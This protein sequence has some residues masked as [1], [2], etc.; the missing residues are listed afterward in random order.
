MRPAD[1]KFWLANVTDRYVRGQMDRRTFLRAASRLGLGAAALGVGSSLARR[2]GIG[3][4]SPAYAQQQ[5]EW[6]E[7][8]TNWL[9]EAAKPF[10]G[11]TI[12]LATEST[13]PSNAINSAL[14]G[15]FVETTGINV[16]IETLPLEQVL[17]KLTLD[18]ASGL[19]TYDLYYLD[20]SWMA[21]F[22]GD[23]IDPREKYESDANL[24]MPNYN[25]DD[26]LPAL[27]DGIS[28]YDGIMVGVPY[29]I[30]IFIQMYRK[31][32][33]D[34]LGLTPATTMEQ[35]LSNA[36]AIQEAK[37][38]DI[39]GTT[40]QMKSGHYSLECDWTAWLWGHGGSVF[41]PDGKFTGNDAA[42]LEAMNYWI[43]LKKTMPEAVTSWTWDG[44]GQSVAQGIAGQILSWGE[45]FPS[46]DD[47]NS[48]QVS[49]LMEA[50][51]PPAATSLRTVD[52]TGYG[53]IPGV[54]HQGGSSLAVSKYSKS[55]G[56]GLALCAMGDLA[57]DPGLDHRPRRWHRPDPLLGLRRP[58]G[59]GERQGRDR[60][61]HAPPRRGARD[62]REPYGLRARPAGL[63]RDLER[64][65]PG[66]A[67][68]VLGRRVR[69]PTGGPRSDQGN[70][71]R[72]RREGLIARH[73]GPP[74]S[75]GAALSPNLRRG[76]DPCPTSRL[77]RSPA[78]R[79]GSAPPPRAP[80]PARGT[81]SC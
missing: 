49:G 38:P 72:H 10:A 33:Y 22:S 47:P 15:Y 20:Q 9:R 36:Q 63:G 64:H 65:D 80:L 44:Q 52:Q 57:R 78:P 7:D 8:M 31:D 77:S 75:R 58:A 60:R 12:R 37:G 17:Q 13:P 66:R 28:M 16:E 19:G 54:G 23:V 70:R 4:I 32:I 6:P 69:R 40:G 27:V 18:V 39:F 1:R 79:P 81:R 45:F 53:E 61:Y 73:R 59:Q 25:I 62:D 14:K 76:T 42:G 41:G 21:A 34:E 46:W 56:R 3:F 67:R 11:Q 50:T 74:S 30:P 35:Y 5:I 48:S 26:F 29:D 51:V 55:A 71:R 43:E 24:A 2:A 68:P